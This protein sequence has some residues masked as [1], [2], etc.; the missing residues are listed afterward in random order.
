MERSLTKII[1]AAW[2][3][4]AA[5]QA[6]PLIRV[7]AVSRDREQI[8]YDETPD[9]GHAKIEGTATLD[10]TTHAPVSLSLMGQHIRMPGGSDMKSV[11]AWNIR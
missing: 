11:F 4:P 9:N 1:I 8:A 6:D 3:G 2:N 5:A 7:E 10:P